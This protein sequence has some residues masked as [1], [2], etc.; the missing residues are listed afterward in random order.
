MILRN[1]AH[2]SLGNPVQILLLTEPAWGFVYA[3]RDPWYRKALYTLP[4]E[5]NYRHNRH[6]N[7]GQTMPPAKTPR[8][9]SFRLSIRPVGPPPSDATLRKLVKEA[10]A[11][12]LE[13]AR[14]ESHDLEAEAIVEGGFLGVGEVAVVLIVK[15]VGGVVVA[16]VAKRAAEKLVDHFADQLR[17][18]NVQ[19]SGAEEMGTEPQTPS[20]SRDLKTTTPT[21]ARTNKA[22]KSEKNKRRRA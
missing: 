5:S 6:V 18:R 17:K 9:L 2:N 16:A 22:R 21:G 10:T 4:L 8:K 1:S 7:G 20:T 15:Y 12:A 14:K 11:A 3:P 13:E 19:P